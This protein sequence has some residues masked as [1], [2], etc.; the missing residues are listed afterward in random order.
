[1]AALEIRTEH[2][3]DTIDGLAYMFTKGAIDYTLLFREDCVE[4][5]KK[6]NKRSGAV[7]N[8]CFWS[9]VN[10]RGAKMA[11]FLSEAV[12]LIRAV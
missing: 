11:K 12:S 7:S 6:N 10:N 5:W 1:M 2:N 8:D 4:V 3:A 9:G